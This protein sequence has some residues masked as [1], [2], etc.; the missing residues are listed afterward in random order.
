MWQ[1]LDPFTRA[2]FIIGVIT[3]IIVISIIFGGIVAKV[4]SAVNRCK[5]RQKTREPID[6]TV[7][8]SKGRVKQL[9]HELRQ[10]CYMEGGGAGVIKYSET[11]KGD[12]LKIVGAGAPGYAENGDLVRVKEVEANS[13]TVENRK[14]FTADF[15]YNCGA[16]RLEPAEWKQDFP[17]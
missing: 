2:M 14:G 10:Q 5:A 6:F 4:E 17:E 11:Q 8:D 12:I 7:Y 16:A 1:E 3:S 9:G 13:V 15:M